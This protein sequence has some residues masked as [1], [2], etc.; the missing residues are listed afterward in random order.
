MEL[1][2]IVWTAKNNISGKNYIE[3]H[4]TSTPWYIVEW[5]SEQHKTA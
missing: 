3:Q 5:Y 1:N 2:R 4:R